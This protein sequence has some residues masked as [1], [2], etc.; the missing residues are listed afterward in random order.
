MIEKIQQIIDSN[1]SDRAKVSLISLA[2]ILDS[3]EKRVEENEQA[4]KE[5]ETYEHQTA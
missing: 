2:L 5:F 3:M 1:L 4:E